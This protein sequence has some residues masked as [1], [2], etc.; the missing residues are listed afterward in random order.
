[1]V[2]MSQEE[3]VSLALAPT[4]FSILRQ[5]SDLLKNAKNLDEARKEYRKLVVDLV[6]GPD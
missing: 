4:R 5:I 6:L 3:A 2:P 1:M